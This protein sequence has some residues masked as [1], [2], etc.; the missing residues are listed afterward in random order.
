MASNPIQRRS[1]QSFLIGFL[2][3]LVIMAFVVVF[4]FTKINKLNEEKEALVVEDITVYVTADDFKSGAI[5]TADSLIPK[6]VRA[7]LDVSNYLTSGSF[8]YDEEGNPIEYIA[9]VDI[10]AGTM[11]TS[12]MVYKE[13]EGRSNDERLMEY[14]MIVLPSGLKNGDYVDIRFD[15]PNGV[16]YIV[17]SKKYVQMTTARGIWM[18]LDELEINSMNSAIVEAYCVNGAQL[19]ATKYTEPGIQEGAV[20]TY[21]INNAVLAAVNA[22]PNVLED[23]RRDLSNKWN[24]DSNPSDG[25]TD[26]QVNRNQIDG[27][28]G[29][30][31]DEDR[32]N[33]VEAGTTTENEAVGTTRDEFV[34]Q[35]EGTGLIGTTY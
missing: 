27:L 10:P 5:I 25:G 28:Y 15:L 7:E 35:L 33:A 31:D 3:A 13:G 19:R 1:R 23:A 22:N 34:A 21:A 29:D 32:R 11:M 30:M 12:G 17:L 18:E 6:T 2:I 9:K 14:N 4:L 26:Y 16:S 24:R 20:T 8:E